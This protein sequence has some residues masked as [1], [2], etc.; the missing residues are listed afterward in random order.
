MKKGLCFKCGDKWSRD[1]V[2][3]FR[4][5]KLILCDPSSDSEEDIVVEEGETVV[6]EIKSLQL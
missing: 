4:H 6:E 2:W 5:M 3:K 1:D